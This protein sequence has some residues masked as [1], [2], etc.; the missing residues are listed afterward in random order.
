[1]PPLLLLIRVDSQRQAAMRH[2]VSS[3]VW[4]ARLGACRAVYARVRAVRV[5][6]GVLH[7]ANEVALPVLGERPPNVQAEAPVG[8]CSLPEKLRR[9]DPQASTR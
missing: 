8:D 5:L 4:G 2:T 9:Q 6:R 1:M 3:R 7:V